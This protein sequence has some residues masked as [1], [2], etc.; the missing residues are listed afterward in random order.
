M[1]QAS[2][3][4]QSTSLPLSGVVFWFASS[5]IFAFPLAT[6]GVYTKSGSFPLGRFFLCIL[7]QASLTSNSLAVSALPVC[8]EYDTSTWELTTCTSVTISQL[9]DGYLI[10]RGMDGYSA[11]EYVIID[12]HDGPGTLSFT[13]FKTGGSDW[14]EFYTNNWE[15]FFQ[16]TGSDQPPD[17]DIFGF[18]QIGWRSQTSKGAGFGWVLTFTSNPNIT[19][20]TATTTAVTVTTATITT[21]TQTTFTQTTTTTLRRFSFDVSSTGCK[22]DIE[23]ECLQNPD[24]PSM[25][26]ASEILC[27]GET[28]LI[29]YSTV[30][31]TDGDASLTMY[32][33]YNPSDDD[34]AKLW[35]SDFPGMSTV[36][37][38]SHVVIILN[39]FAHWFSNVVHHLELQKPVERT[40]VE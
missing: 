3:M 25:T 35:F 2:Q 30:F 11:G 19:S 13:D 15:E 27:I 20:T 6:L 40:T 23:Q 26:N 36:P 12:L 10:S 32:H 39:L 37:F 29:L 7:L 28:N 14:V 1:I 38:L 33:M 24:F 34:D 31:Q 9:D 4:P 5:F 17:T 18:T 21:F 22:V 16:F 8:W